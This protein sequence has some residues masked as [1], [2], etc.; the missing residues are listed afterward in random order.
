MKAREKE[1]RDADINETNIA[2]VNV[3][4]LKRVSRVKITFANHEVV[5]CKKNMFDSFPNIRVG[6]GM[7]RQQV[8][9]GAKLFKQVTPFV[10]KLSARVNTMMHLRE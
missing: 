8:K 6:E 10:F 5:C 7:G 4:L 9:R 1:R 2:S 3:Q